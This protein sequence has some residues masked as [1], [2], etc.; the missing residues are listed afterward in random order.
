MRVVLTLINLK[1]LYH[2]HAS[3]FLRNLLENIYFLLVIT[4]Q[5][6]L[7]WAVGLSEGDWVNMVE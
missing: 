5:V 6:S 7:L 3:F 4:L 2:G 1:G